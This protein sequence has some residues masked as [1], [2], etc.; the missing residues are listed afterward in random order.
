MMPSCC[1]RVDAV[2]CLFSGETQKQERDEGCAA[3]EALTAPGDAGKP[4]VSSPTQPSSKNQY[5]CFPHPPLPQPPSE[6]ITMVGK[7]ITQ[8]TDGQETADLEEVTREALTEEQRCDPGPSPPS[9]AS[10]GK[11]TTA[12]Q[13]HLPSMQ[14]EAKAASVEGDRGV[15]ESRGTRSTVQT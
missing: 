11:C 5:S 15:S 1:Q 14:S 3:A 13:N 9:L 10:Q 6:D 4:A 8:L 12:L 7:G 2:P